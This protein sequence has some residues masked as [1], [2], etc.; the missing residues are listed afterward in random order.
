M[1]PES[2]AVRKLRAEVYREHQADL[3]ALAGPAQAAQQ[4]L[5]VLVPRAQ[6]EAFVWLFER[7]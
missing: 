2:E 4:A 6:R 1:D 7:R 3:K 5:D